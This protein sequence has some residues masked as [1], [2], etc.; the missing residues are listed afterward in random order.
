MPEGED[1]EGAS[2]PPPHPLDRVWFHPSEL[3]AYMAAT[4]PRRGTRSWIVGGLA[5]VAGAALTLGILFI[6]GALNGGETVRAPFVAG[7][8]SP[9]ASDPPD[10]SS[11]ATTAAQSLVTVAI[12]EPDG[13][14]ARIATG[15]SVSKDRILT[16]ARPL[17][18]ALG[19][20]TPANLVI[21]TPGSKAAAAQVIGTDPETDLT[22][23]H[24]EGADVP[25]PR[26]GTP[27]G[28]RVGDDVVAVARS[29]T[30]R[31]W[32]SSGVVSV[33]NQ[34]VTLPGGPSYA[35]LIGTDTAANAD[36]A[37]G[38]L[39]DSDGAVVGILMASPDGL[40]VPI[41]LARAVFDQ[42]ASS[43]K[44]AH[45][46]LGVWGTAVLDRAGGGVRVEGVVGLS[47]ASKVGIAPGDI[48]TAVGDDAVSDMGDLVAAVRR[49]L[50]HD[51][52]DVTII[53][54][55]HRITKNAQLTDGTQLGPTGQ[56]GG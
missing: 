14:L 5:A 46:Y 21:V 44:A 41:D 17:A 43:G 30:G 55:G 10:V 6:T 18:A 16:A 39:L 27:D 34:L 12:R 45:G 9:V 22:L 7:T 8:A 50:P 52:V 3:S 38:A 4:G 15:V 1:P 31:E 40:A 49:R 42:L 53:R 25:I 28:L 33:V 29:A 35:G 2:G 47:P 19:F 48:I 36:D 20:A 13:D 51:P 32:V 37:G 56:T 24:V 54:D 26:W 23:L 11:S